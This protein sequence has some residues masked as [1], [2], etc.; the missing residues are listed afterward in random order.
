M[1]LSEFKDEH[2]RKVAI[3]LSEVIAVDIGCH[4]NER[5]TIYLKSGASFEVDDTYENIITLIK[6]A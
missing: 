2:G 3:K 5:P 6:A 4:S 1:R